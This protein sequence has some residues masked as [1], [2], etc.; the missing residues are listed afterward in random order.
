MS[1]FVLSVFVITHPSAV[2]PF[3]SQQFIIMKKSFL[4]IHKWCC[5]HQK[6]DSDVYWLVSFYITSHTAWVGIFFIYKISFKVKFID[7]FI[8][9]IRR[10][11]LFLLY[12]ISDLIQVIQQRCTAICFSTGAHKLCLI[13]K[14]TCS[15]GG[16]FTCDQKQGW[17]YE[18]LHYIMQQSGKH[19]N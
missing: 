15:Y 9:L 2:S 1:R 16:K 11:L 13:L 12:Q 7:V 3:I 8:H 14:V 4:I 5:F 10:V 19:A 17:L 18:Y 6:P